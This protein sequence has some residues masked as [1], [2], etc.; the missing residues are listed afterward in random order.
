MGEQPT[1]LLIFT[2]FCKEEAMVLSQ[3]HASRVTGSEMARMAY[4]SSKQPCQVGPSVQI[5]NTPF[6][7]Q[8]A[9]QLEVE[10]ALVSWA[11][12]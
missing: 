3:H 11:W 5:N 10:Y 4:Q 6:H 7:N 9:T 12:V 2:P 8:V 1:N